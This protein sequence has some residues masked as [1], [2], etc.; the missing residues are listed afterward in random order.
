MLYNYY[1]NVSIY[2]SH[3][4]YICYNYDD[5]FLLMQYLCFFITAIFI[6][7][8]RNE[9]FTIPLILL[10]IIFPS[11]YIDYVI[12]DVLFIGNSCKN[13]YQINQ[14]YI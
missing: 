10:L 5:G 6:A 2:K 9:E 7:M 1:I 11:L 3:I 14:T 13:I 12:V 8:Y 4:M